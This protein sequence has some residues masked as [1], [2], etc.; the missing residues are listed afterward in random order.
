MRDRID[1]SNCAAIIIG[2]RWAAEVGEW[3][4]DGHGNDDDSDEEETVG[5]GV[6]EEWE[7]GV[8]VKDVS[9]GAVKDGDTGLV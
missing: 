8:I 2:E 5:A 9:Y 6:D 4:P 1:E 3:L 7:L